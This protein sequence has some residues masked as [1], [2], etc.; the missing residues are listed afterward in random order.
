MS[1][2]LGAAHAG[3]CLDSQIDRIKL[4]ARMCHASG[5]IFVGDK[6]VAAMRAT[7]TVV[8]EPSSFTTTGKS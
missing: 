1:I 3:D 8:S 4:G 6:P 7:F 5:A 2:F